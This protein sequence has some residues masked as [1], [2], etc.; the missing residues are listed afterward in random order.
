[1]I[2]TTSKYWHLEFN[3]KTGQKVCV[4]LEPNFDSFDL[5]RN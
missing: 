5:F 1:M 2:K 4:V 3:G